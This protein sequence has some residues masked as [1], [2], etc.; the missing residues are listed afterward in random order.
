MLAFKLGPI[1][2]P[3][4][5]KAKGE[6][7]KKKLMLTAIALSIVFPL[8][9]TLVLAEGPTNA[10]G[11][12]AD[13]AAEEWGFPFL[14]NGMAGLVIAPEGAG[15]RFG[16]A[17]KIEED[18]VTIDVSEI[19]EATLNEDTDEWEGT[20][21]MLKIS[22]AWV[23]YKFWLNGAGTVTITYTYDDGTIVNKEA[24]EFIFFKTKIG[25]EGFEKIILQAYK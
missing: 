20:W 23:A 13:E 22:P 1:W 2:W 8:I 21:V 10:G 7:M 19:P 9:T 25:E 14:Y 15:Q 12:R 17:T 6:K 24:T 11:K 16:T 3:W 18:G 4:P 5:Q